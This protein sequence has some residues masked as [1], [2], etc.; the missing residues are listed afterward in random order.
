MPGGRPWAAAA[1]PWRTC[2]G[3]RIRVRCAS[4]RPRLG[5][6]RLGSWAS[7]CLC[8]QPSGARRRNHDVSPGG[9]A[10][11]RH[12]HCIR[13]PGRRARR[14]DR[15]QHR[16]AAGRRASRRG[17]GVSC[18]SAPAVGSGPARS[19]AA[20]AGGPRIRVGRPAAASSALLAADL[21]PARSAGAPGRR[22]RAGCSAPRLLPADGLHDMATLI[23]AED[24][25]DLE[26]L[27]TITRPPCC[28]WA[29]ETATTARI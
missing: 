2:A 11:R 17:H 7:C 1:G 22:W 24:D 26:R 13:R 16:P 23:E 8:Q 28:W 10:G 25:F 20:A 19:P 18:W 4:S 15:R 12:R 21:V 5:G 6:P 9:R 27:P 3:R 29:V 14:V